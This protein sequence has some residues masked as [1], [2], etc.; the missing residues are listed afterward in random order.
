VVT[1]HIPLPLRVTHV[2]LRTSKPRLLDRNKQKT[3]PALSQLIPAFRTRGILPL[4]PVLEGRASKAFVRGVGM[5]GLVKQSRYARGRPEVYAY[6][7][8]RTGD[9]RRFHC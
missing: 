5:D 3:V 4:V 6:P 7:W 2:D 1:L 9:G 8:V